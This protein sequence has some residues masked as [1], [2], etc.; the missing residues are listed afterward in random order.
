MAV[1]QPTEEEE[2]KAT[3][4]AVGDLVLA[5]DNQHHLAATFGVHIDDFRRFLFG[6]VSLTPSVR[7]KMREFARTGE[8]NPRG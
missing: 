7:H 6:E 4:D 5:G 8:R 1:K 2:I 3:K